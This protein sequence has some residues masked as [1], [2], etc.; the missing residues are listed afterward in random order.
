[1][2]PYEP[3]ILK[4]IDNK[5]N[6]TILKQ[7]KL[8]PNTIKDRL[9]MQSEFGGMNLASAEEKSIVGYIAT[10]LNEGINSN[11]KIT[12][13]V[14]EQRV[15]DSFSLISARTW[16]STQKNPNKRTIPLDMEFNDTIDTIIKFTKILGLE[17]N[18]FEEQKEDLQW[19]KSMQ[20]NSFQ[21][22]F[23]F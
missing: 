3:K 17:I 6:E 1:M 7:L 8:P 16:I 21:W 18:L 11:S 14:I 2:G 19:E 15:K 12:K 10:F 20:W 23:G 9:R 5:I 13:Q 4:D 22:T